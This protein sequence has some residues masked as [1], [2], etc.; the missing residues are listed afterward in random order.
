LKRIKV[1]FKVDIDYVKEFEVDDDF[2]GE[3]YGWEGE[4]VDDL[5][6]EFSIYVSDHVTFEGEVDE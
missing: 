4:I 2:D 1:R 6:R 5:N 3:E